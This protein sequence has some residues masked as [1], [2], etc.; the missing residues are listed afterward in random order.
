[1]FQVEHPLVRRLRALD[2]DDLS[3]K[4]ALQILYE[5]GSATRPRDEA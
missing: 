3:P 1:M 4:E 5:L 2:P